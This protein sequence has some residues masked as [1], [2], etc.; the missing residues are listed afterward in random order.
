M[1]DVELDIED[2]HIIIRPVSNQR[3][4]MRVSEYL[5]GRIYVCILLI[6]T[7]VY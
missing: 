7:I 5:P 6:N 3:A 2:D 4:G 1:E